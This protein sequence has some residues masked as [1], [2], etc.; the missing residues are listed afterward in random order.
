M[1]SRSSGWSST[2]RIRSWAAAT[3]STPM[4][5]FRLLAESPEA[6]VDRRR[7]EGNC[8]GD[9]QLDLRAGSGLAPEL[10]FRAD[11]FG[12]LA[13]AGQAP[14]SRPVPLIQDARVNAASIVPDTQ[15]E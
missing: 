12:A 2:T 13:H 8:P 6:G 5:W 3:A 4:R 14:M 1:P 7:P 10:D 11:P 9:A 15:P